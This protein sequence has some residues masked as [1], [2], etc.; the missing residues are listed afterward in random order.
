MPHA[1]AQGWFNGRHL[2]GPALRDSF[3]ELAKALGVGDL[4]P[5]DWTQLDDALTNLRKGD[6]PY[7]GMRPFAAADAAL[8]F[9]REKQLA[10]LHEVVRTLHYHSQLCSRHGEMVTRTSP[11]LGEILQPERHDRGVS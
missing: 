5:P 1:T 2:P 4:I 3:A 11:A 9:G 8:F 7:V 6:A 10:P